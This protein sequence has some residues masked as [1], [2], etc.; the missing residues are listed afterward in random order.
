MELDSKPI[1][2]S[3]DRNEKNSSLAFISHAH[4]DHIAAAKSKKKPKIISSLETCSLINAVYGLNPELYKSESSND[5]ISMLDAGHMLGSKQLCIDAGNGRTVYTGDYQMQRSMVSKPLDYTDADTLIMDSTYPDPD[6]KFG[7]RAETEMLLQEWTEKRLDEGI[8]LFGSYAMGKA[9]EII[10][11]LNKI[12]ITP[13]VSRKI[14]EVN[15]VYVKYGY[16]LKSYP[17]YDTPD[18][19]SIFSDN[20]VGVI[21]NNMLKRVSE[22]LYASHKKHVFTAVATGFAKVYKFSTDA[23][24][25]ISDHADF[26]QAIEL[27]ERVKPRKIYTYGNNDVKFAHNLSNAGYPAAPYPGGKTITIE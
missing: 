17:A 26:N 5:G 24:F 3:L 25:A 14:F 7:D 19:T 23:Q 18:D 20:F 9:Q 4:S 13:A 8:V 11:I 12:G 6:I 10:S 16:N 22:M 2:I 1:S 21:E 27:V 15:K